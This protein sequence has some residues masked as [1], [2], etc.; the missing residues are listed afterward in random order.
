MEYL[1]SQLKKRVSSKRFIH[2]LGVSETAEKLAKLYNAPIE[3]AKIAGLLHD[4]AKDLQ[5]DEAREYI[6]Q[7]GLKLDDV[8]KFDINLAHG[9]IGAE[10]VKRELNISD[11]DILNAIKYHT[12]GREN[13]S[14]LEKIVYIADYI[15]PSRDFP[16]VDELRQAAFSNLDEGILLALDKTITYVVKKGKLLHLNSILARNSIIVNRNKSL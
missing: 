4:Y 1:T 16:G 9:Q 12:T 5:D 8:L 3:K 15:E 10:L 11:S 14:I 7:F 2:S 13:M 6:V